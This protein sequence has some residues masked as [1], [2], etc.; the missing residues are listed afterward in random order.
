MIRKASTEQLR[1]LLLAAEAVTSDVRD[2]SVKLAGNRYW[3]ASIASH[4]GQKGGLADHG[5]N[6]GCTG[7][8]P[9]VGDLKTRSATD[10]FTRRQMTSAPPQSRRGRRRRLGTDEGGV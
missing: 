2:G 4:A 8:W 1:Q 5:R 3:S 6:S 7:R 10:C 9:A